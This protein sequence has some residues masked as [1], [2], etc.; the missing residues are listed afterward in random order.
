MTALPP[1]SVGGVHV[2]ETLALPPVAVRIV[3]TPGAVGLGV[4]EFD[5]TDCGPVPA[6]VIAATWNVYAVPLVS[7][8]SA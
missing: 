7:P 2:R 6:A 5:A 3:G 1:L 4:T 8:A